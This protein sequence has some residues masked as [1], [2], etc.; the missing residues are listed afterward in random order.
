MA[1][2]CDL[3]LCVCVCVAIPVITTP[4]SDMAVQSGEDVMFECFTTGIPDPTITWFR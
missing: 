4:P 2:T 1:L 3:M